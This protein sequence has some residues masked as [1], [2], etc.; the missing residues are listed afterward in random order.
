MKDWRLLIVV[1]GLESA[2]LIGASW[3]LFVGIKSGFIKRKMKRAGVPVEGID[4]I[5]AGVVYSLMALFSLWAAYTLWEQWTA[6]RV[7]W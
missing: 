1:L 3:F 6:G 7:H 2:L 4:A 5:R